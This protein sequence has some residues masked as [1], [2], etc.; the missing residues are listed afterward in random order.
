MCLQRIF[1]FIF[2]LHVPLLQISSSSSSVSTAQQFA[3]RFR[4]IFG[5]RFSISTGNASIQT[6]LLPQSDQIHQHVSLFQV[7]PVDQHQ[8]R[9]QNCPR[10]LEN[11]RQG[12]IQQSRLTKEETHGQMTT[13]VVESSVNSQCFSLFG[14]L[15]KKARLFMCNNLTYYTEEYYCM[16]YETGVA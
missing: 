6:L 5:L 16:S 11:E 4:E 15:N 12:R 10:Q 14:A 13:V 8:D 7:G 2:M 9:W 1:P 3:L